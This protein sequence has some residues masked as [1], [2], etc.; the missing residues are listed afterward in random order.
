MRLRIPSLF[1]MLK[2]RAPTTLFGRSFLIIVLPIAVMQIAVTWF[3]FDSY[4]QRVNGHLT[5]GLA[6][7]IAW[8]IQGYETDPSP[9]GLKRLEDRAEQSLDLSIVFQPNGK[10][11]TVRHFAL[12]GIDRALNTA[13][14]DRIDAPYWFDTTRYP[15]YVDIRVKVTSGVLRIIAPRDRA[16]ATQAYSFIVWLTLKL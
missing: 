5:E 4:W 11:P 10:L 1:R 9:P 15:G 14:T 6:G 13:L 7:D 2:R 16:F 3:F 8:V 12:F